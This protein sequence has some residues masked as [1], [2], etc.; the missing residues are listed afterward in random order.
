MRVHNP[1]PGEVA[2]RLSILCLKVYNANLLKGDTSHFEAERVELTDYVQARYGEHESYDFFVAGIDSLLRINN[3]IWDLTEAQHKFEAPDKK[4]AAWSR[5]TVQ[6]N[7]L[8]ASLVK[9]INSRFGVTEGEK[10]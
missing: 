5:E 1:R 3:Q 2:D 6:L 7:D 10:I 9:E 8:R 4:Y